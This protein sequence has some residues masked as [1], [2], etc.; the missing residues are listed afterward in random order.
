MGY[1]HRCTRANILLA[2]KGIRG[3]KL[4]E[5]GYLESP[6]ECYALLEVGSPPNI[7]TSDTSRSLVTIA[8]QWL[9]ANTASTVICHAK[10]SPPLVVALLLVSEDIKDFCPEIT[11][12][13][14]SIQDLITGVMESHKEPLT[15]LTVLL[16]LL[17][18]AYDNGWGFNSHLRNAGVPLALLYAERSRKEPEKY[19]VYDKKSASGSIVANVCY[20]KLEGALNCPGWGRAF[21]MIVAHNDESPALLY[22]H[23]SSPP[24]NF[25]GA[26]EDY[27]ISPPEELPKGVKLYRGSKDNIENLVFQNEKSL[28]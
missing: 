16:D 7:E 5:N 9:S 13:Y 10:W 3:S 27:S 25:K 18:E 1:P 19:P 24:L 26:L 2:T 21:K 20:K 14:S 12:A 15:Q 11:N 23:P 6:K 4:L 22:V 17:S 8:H 28:H